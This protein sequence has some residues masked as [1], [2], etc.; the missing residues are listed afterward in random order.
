[1]EKLPVRFCM[2]FFCVT[3][4]FVINTAA[5]QNKNY[6]SNLIKNP[7]AEEDNDAA[8]NILAWQPIPFVQ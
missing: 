2:T 6:N 3:L 8:N 4:F 5:Q 7:G 1:M